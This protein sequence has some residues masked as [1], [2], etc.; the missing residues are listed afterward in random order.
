MA[1]ASKKFIGASARHCKWVPCPSSVI[2]SED[3]SQQY[4]D[5]PAVLAGWSQDAKV[6][7]GG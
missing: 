3:G 7:D 2:S 6:C 5:L 1:V 4:E